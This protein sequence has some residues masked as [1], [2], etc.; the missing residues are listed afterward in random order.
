LPT[1]E[2]WEYAARGPDRRPNLW[3]ADPLDRQMTRAFAGRGAT[4]APV[5]M[6]HQ[7]RTPD[8]SGPI[9]DLAGNVQEW[10]LGL[11]RGDR[12]GED[13]ADVQDGETSV[14]ALRGLPL[15][16]PPPGSIQ[17]ESAAYRERLC[18]TGPCVEKTRKLLAYVGFR[19]ARPLAR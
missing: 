10:T 3:G 17:P 18:A 14:R 12:P 7:D 19:C 16:E 4:P 6:N 11:W 5:M 15:G 8:P 13:E 9:W 2:Q 1:E